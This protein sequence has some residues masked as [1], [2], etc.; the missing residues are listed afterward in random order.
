ME[1]LGLNEMQW[2]ILA[3][4]SSGIFYTIGRYTGILDAIDFFNDEQ[5]MTSLDFYY[6]LNILNE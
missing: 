5:T 4:T 2:L 1:L 3:I 6:Y